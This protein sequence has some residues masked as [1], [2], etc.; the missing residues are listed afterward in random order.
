CSRIGRHKL[1]IVVIYKRVK[2]PVQARRNG[3]VLRGR[4][5]IDRPHLARRRANRHL[6]HRLPAGGRSVPPACGS[7]TRLLAKADFYETL[8]VPRGA[9]EKELKAA[10]RKLAMKF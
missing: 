5:A 1:T 8:G 4:P 7:E 9:D 3:F 2:T 6:G 10:F